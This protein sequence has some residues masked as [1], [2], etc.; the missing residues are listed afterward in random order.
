MLTDKSRRHLDAE[1]QQWL[2]AGR[3]ADIW[4]RD[5]DATA[6]TPA[7]QRLH[8]LSEASDAPIA[9]ACIPA[10]VDE[11]LAACIEA[12][13]LA[14]VWQHGYAH[15]NHAPL[16]EKKIELGPHRSPG[17]VIAEL[18]RG[19]RRLRELFGVR[20]AAVLVPPWNRIDD[21]VL[22]RLGDT[23]LSGLSTFKPRRQRNIDAGLWQVNTHV[24]LI[25]WRGGGGFVGEDAAVS[26][27]CTHL[28]LRREG[29]TDGAEPTGILSHHLVHDESVWQ[30]LSSWFAY[31][32]EHRGLRLCA[33]QELHADA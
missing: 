26:A 32:A 20:F 25:D 10:K 13:P 12:W 28:R 29:A 2:S 27:I 17:T 30:F 31:V 22:A 15:C 11:T 33:P 8:A 6:F 3:S 4:W 7:L 16:G 5:D 9:L 14:S 18:Q 19:S 24:D 21:T 1:L 23:T